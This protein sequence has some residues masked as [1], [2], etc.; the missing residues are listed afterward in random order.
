MS[1]VVDGVV[2]VPAAWPSGEVIVDGDW[3]PF[4]DEEDRP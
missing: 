3:I 4:E 2:Y 1:R